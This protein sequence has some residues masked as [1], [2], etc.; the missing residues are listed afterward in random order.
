MPVEF[1][2]WIL[3]VYDQGKEIELPEWDPS[4]LPEYHDHDGQESRPE[5]ARHHH[6]VLGK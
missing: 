1:L 6:E 4:Q 3:V 5:M 2:A